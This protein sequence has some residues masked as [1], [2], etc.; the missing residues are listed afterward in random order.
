MLPRPQ[1]A[2]RP[3]PGL[4]A[5]SPDPHPWTWHP[6]RTADLP[7]PMDWPGGLHSWLTPLTVTGPV[8]LFLVR[9]CGTAPWPVRSRTLPALLRLS[10][11]PWCAFADTALHINFYPWWQLQQCLSSSPPTTTTEGASRRE[12]IIDHTK[13]V[14]EKGNTGLNPPSLK[15]QKNPNRQKR[16][17]KKTPNKPEL[18]FVLNLPS[19]LTISE[20]LFFISPCKLSWESISLSSYTW[21]FFVAL[22]RSLFNLQSKLVKTTMKQRNGRPFS[23]TLT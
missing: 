16:I 18:T 10:A 17:T 11:R 23:H 6:G 21:S 7:V 14:W 22:L 20:Q 3:V 1:A 12:Q 2:A 19:S 8:Q 9:A 15:N 5:L 4:T 13:N